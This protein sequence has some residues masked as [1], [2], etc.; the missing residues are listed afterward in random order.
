MKFI[1]AVLATG[2]LSF[3]AGIYMPW[4]WLFAVIAFLIAL[5]VHQKPGKAFLAGF[6][7]LFVLWAGLSIWI[8]IENKGILAAKIAKLLPLGGSPV[9][10]IIVTGVI[11]GLVAGFAALSGSF[12]RTSKQ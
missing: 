12:L 2:L 5:L 9:L 10:L 7:G 6:L 8:N 1:V 3:A 4:W 11:A